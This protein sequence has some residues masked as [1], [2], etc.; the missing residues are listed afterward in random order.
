M[1]DVT[2]RDPLTGNEKGW[3]GSAPIT[4]MK[5]RLDNP[6][7][8]EPDT[9]KNLAYLAMGL[10]LLVMVWFISKRAMKNRMAMLEASGPKIAGD[11]V[12]EGGA[13]NPQWRRIRERVLGCPVIS[14][15]APP[16][17]GVARLARLAFT[18]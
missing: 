7:S 8:M 1:L 12:L 10:T 9:T 13:R 15:Q 6:D 3:S 5:R 17:Q 4:T 11:D 14:S 16:A 18:S 2:W